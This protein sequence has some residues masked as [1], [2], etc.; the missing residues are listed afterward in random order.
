MPYRSEKIKIAGTFY[1]RR[2][3]LTAEEREEIK[4]LYKTSVHSQ[5]KLAD[6]FHVSRS[7]IGMVVNPE[8]LE[9]VR[10]LFKERRREGKYKV[11]KEERARIIREHRRYKQRLFVEGKIQNSMKNEQEETKSDF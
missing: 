9:R 10:E 11:S 3:K 2:V 7:L 4:Y 6:M 1:D 8:R 5:R